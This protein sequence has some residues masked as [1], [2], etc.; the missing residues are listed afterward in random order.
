MKKT[1]LSL[2]KSFLFVFGAA[3]G[4]TA[5]ADYYYGYSAEK[6]Y[7]VTVT[8]LTKGQSF[9]PILAAAHTRSISFFE[10]GAPASEELATLAEAGN[11]APLKAVLDDSSRVGGTA[12]S[13]GLLA[14]GASVTIPLVQEG[15]FSRLSLSAMLIPTNDTFVAIDGVRLPSWGGKVEYFANA[16]DAGSETNTENCVDIPGPAC[17]GAG[18]SPDDSGEGYVYVSPGISGEAELTRNAYDWRGS[19]AKITIR[20]VK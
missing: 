16:Y 8:N 5:T 2:A 18:L 11:I 13:E 3:V 17:G 1:T 15:R 14:P 19:V 6:E 20:R 4:T 10:L 12:S 7:E 9:T